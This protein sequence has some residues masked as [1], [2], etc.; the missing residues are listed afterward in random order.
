MV[1]AKNWLKRRPATDRRGK[2]T[3][4]EII[5]LAA[6]RNSVSQPGYRH[7]GAVQ[8]VGDVMGGGL[9]VDCRVQREDNL[10]HRRVVGARNEPIDGEVLRAD[11]VER[12]QRAAQPVIA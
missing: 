8:K 1:K 12:R 3:L 6:D 2:R 5:E 7:F 9:A 4:V 11:A 10:F